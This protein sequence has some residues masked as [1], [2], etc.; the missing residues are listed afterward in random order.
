MDDLKRATVSA[1]ALSFT[2][3][4]VLLLFVMNTV[5][6]PQAEASRLV[7]FV[8]ILVLTYATIFQWMRCARTYIDHTIDCR[9]A[10]EKK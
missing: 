3:V 7:S 4:C 9:F 8:A 2:L 10:A 6:Q 5:S 1:V